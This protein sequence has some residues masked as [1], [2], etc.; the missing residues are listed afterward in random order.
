M[1]A[2]A[3]PATLLL[4][5][6]VLVG[7]QLR[8]LDPLPLSALRLSQSGCVG[9]GGVGMAHNDTRTTLEQL[10]VSILTGSLRALAGP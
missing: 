8:L 5:V 4:V 10:T 9:C 2:D 6:V 3:M 7:R 1:D